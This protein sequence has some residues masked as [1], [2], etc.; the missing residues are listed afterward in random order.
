MNRITHSASNTLL[1]ETRS[2][3]ASTTNQQYP[4]RRRQPREASKNGPTAF[5]TEGNHTT[6]MMNA[7]E[8]ITQATRVLT[9]LGRSFKQFYEHTMTQQ[10]M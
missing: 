10:E 7:L 2:E 6:L 9:D 4:S 8:D 3:P 1:R 5:S